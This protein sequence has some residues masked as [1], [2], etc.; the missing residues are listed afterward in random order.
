MVTAEYSAHH[1][2]VLEG[3]E[4][5]RKRPGMYIGST[6]SRGLMHCLWEIIDNSV[7]EALGGFGTRI[8]ILLH[9][10]GSV[11]VRDRARGIPVDIEPRTGLSGV[12]VVFTKLHAGGKFGGGSYAASGGL[13]GVGASVVN[14]LSERLDV[15]VDRGGKTWAMSFRRGEPGVFANGSPDSDFRAFDA[16]SELR[17][18]GKVAKGVTGTR[19]R[20]WADRQIFTKDAAFGL[21]ELVQRARQ[22]AF[23]VPGLEIVIRDER[24]AEAGATETSFKYD[25]GISEFAEFLAPDS[26]VTEVWRLQGSGGFTET[27]PVLQASGAMVPTEVERQCEVDVAMRWG[28]GY[29]TTVRSFVNII[30][31]PKGGTHQQGFEQGLMK[32]VRAQVEANARRLKVGNDKLEKDDIMAGLTVVL[33][34]RLPE[35]QFEGQTK[36]VL[37]TPAVRQIVSNV[38]ARGITERLTSTRRDDKLQSALLLDKIVAEMKARI[39]ARAHKETQRRKNALESSSLPAKLVD[40]RSN[41]VADS[42]LFIVEGDSALGTAKLARDSEHQALLP[43]RGKIL[44]VQKASVSDMLSNAECA[45]IIQVVGAGSGRSFDLEAARYGK[46]ILMSDADVDGAHIRTLLLTLFFRYMRPLIEDGRVFAAVPPLHRVIV[47]G[48]GSRAAE[49]LYTY[50]EQELH[51]LLA[52]LSKAGR[53]WQEP[54]QRY[55]GLGE[56]DAEQ[57]ATTTMDRAGRTLRRVRVED[58][59]AATSVF[60]MLMGNDV[61]PRREFIVTS[62]DRLGRERIDA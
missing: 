26:A 20:Y 53:R 7:D 58:A 24:D 38:V 51:G 13:H 8:D 48:R 50:S 57:L 22:T 35:P 19:I 37:G 16:Q 34:V 14:A 40:C 39:S 3:L 17:T 5:V 60:E 18:T 56:M 11:E 46:I 2:Q 49:T 4:A 54:I 1:L 15:E 25:G 29:E 36:E 21:D 9:A 6:D 47:N 31:T 23:L 27:V 59:E 41:D 10:D 12:E 45:S 42:E 52:K 61:A 28:T 33:T 44:N 30:A 62:S 32:S 43:I 55:K